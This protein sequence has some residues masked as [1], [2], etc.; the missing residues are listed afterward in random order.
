MT[1]CIP[2]ILEDDE[3]VFISLSLYNWWLVCDLVV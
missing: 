2:V 3:E 1:D